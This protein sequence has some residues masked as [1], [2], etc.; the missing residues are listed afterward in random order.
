MTPALE[1]VENVE[2]SGK[3]TG[4]SIV[5]LTLERAVSLR[6]LLYLIIGRC[7]RGELLPK[8][9][10]YPRNPFFIGRR[11]SATLERVSRTLEEETYRVDERSIE[12]EQ[13]CEGT[14]TGHQMKLHHSTLRQGERDDRIA[15]APVFVSASRNDDELSSIQ[16][17]RHRSRTCPR[18]ELSLP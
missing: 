17:V 15:L 9:S 16:H 4:Q 11:G 18:R 3:R 14:G 8:W 12:I 6:E 1:N 2:H 5:M 7:E 13:D 10:T